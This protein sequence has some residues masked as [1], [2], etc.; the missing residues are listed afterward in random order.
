MKPTKKMNAA[1]D[2]L[3]QL[4]SKYKVPGRVIDRECIQCFTFEDEN[5]FLKTPLKEL[6]QYIIG[7]WSSACNINDVGELKYK[8]FIPR[9]LDLFCHEGT[10]FSVLFIEHITTAIGKFEY[11]K[12]FSSKE[13]NA[14]DLFF[15]LYLENEFSDPDYGDPVELFQI[16]LTGFDCVAFLKKQRTI[17]PDWE[18]IKTELL[19]YKDVIENAAIHYDGESFAKWIELGDRQ[20]AWNFLSENS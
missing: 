15:T 5:Y 16:A 1:V 12:N 3:Y 20:Q 8:Y 2:E 9:I 14:I 11:R 4:F 6:N 13:I 7:A 10:D 18:R 17:S 19:K